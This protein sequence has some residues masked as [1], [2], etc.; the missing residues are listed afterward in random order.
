MIVNRKNWKLKVFSFILCFTLVL[1]NLSSLAYANVTDEITLSDSENPAPQIEQTHSDSNGYKVTFVEEEVDVTLPMPDSKIVTL[2]EVITLPDGGSDVASKLGYEFIGWQVPANSE[3]S[4]TDGWIDPMEKPILS[5]G[6]KV[7]FGYDAEFVAVFSKGMMVDYVDGVDGEDIAV[8]EHSFHQHDEPFPLAGEGS[9]EPKRPGYHF[10]GWQ[11]PYSSEVFYTATEEYIEPGTILPAGTS[12]T[13][14]HD[15]TFTAVWESGHMVTYDDGVTTETIVV[16]I[17]SKLYLDRENVT[18]KG[19]GTELPTRSGYE[20]VGWKLMEGADLNYAD[21]TFIP[22]GTILQPNDV[23]SIAHDVTLYAQW[24]P[25]RVNTS[26]NSGSSGGSSGGSSSTPV[27]TQTQP[28]PVETI[29]V[30][31]LPLAPDP[32][33]VE[34][35]PVPLTQ[36]LLPKTGVEDHMMAYGLGLILCF[37]TAIYLH[38]KKRK[39]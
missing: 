16:P 5:A 30:D 9:D 28:A 26:S 22:E 35:T 3:I 4:D 21:G 11:V 25:V 36:L 8:P 31:P 23:F 33:I 10:V 34:E 37:S 27:V 7:S 39:H 15:T 32:I 2:E 19:A 14:G 38:L 24:E 18:V 6:T 17:D 12:V 13:I 29:V 20:F 1:G